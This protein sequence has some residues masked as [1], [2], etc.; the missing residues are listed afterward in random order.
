MDIK[1]VAWSNLWRNRGRYLAYLGSAAFAVMVYFLFNAVVLHPDFQSGYRGARYAVA[2]MR[3]GAVV[4]AAFTFFFLLFAHGSLIRFRRREFGLMRLMG[5]TRGQLVRLLLWESVITAAAS[6][7]VGSGLGL[8]FARLFF[9][10]ISVI[11]DLPEPIPVYAGAPVWLRTAGVFGAIF[12]A[13]SLQSIGEVMKHSIAELLRS[14]RR[15]KEPP[16]YSRG[17]AVLGTVL[18]AVGYAWAAL[19][20]QEHMFL[21]SMPV[22]AMVSV[23]TYLLIHEG[24]IALLNRLR[25]NERGFYRPVPF[26]HLSQLLFKL[27][28]NARTLTSVSLLVAVILT[29]MGTIYSVYAL[30][31]EDALRGQVHSLEIARFGA[32][33]ADLA[34]EAEGFTMLLEDQGLEVPHHWSLLTAWAD[35]SSQD[36]MGSVILVPYSIYRDM[37]EAAGQPAL[38]APEPDDALAVGFGPVSGANPQPYV[39]TLEDQRLEGLA[40]VDEGRSLFYLQWALV[41]ADETFARLTAQAPEDRRIALAAW[42]TSPDLGRQA[43]AAH[44]AVREHVDTG[45]GDVFLSRAVRYDDQVSQWSIV[46]FMAVFA[47]L[48][49]FAACCSLIY[50]RL[51][52]EIEDDRRY[53]RRLSDL[54]VGRDL[55]RQVNRRQLVTLFFVPF[56]IGSVHFTFAM[57]ALSITVGYSVIHYG[58]LMALGYLVLYA[59]YF[60]AV[61]GFYWRSLRLGG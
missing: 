58:W 45:S 13:V 18:L 33:A 12:A 7:A 11:L 48:V 25:R 32:G 28:D 57:R 39:L 38:P 51:S 17:K 43:I 22:T 16:T 42:D 44:S 59:L 4:V 49:F 40:H 52:A 20:D 36:L 3:A 2:A 14:R 61:Q 15:T 8:L 10:A 24:S 27:K 26:L 34:A 53:Y 56:L 60:L 19:G 55:L 30:A 21:A 41:V 1:R 5:F 54:G 23:G 37:R 31:R 46:L 47:S 6:L 9:M 35:L 29:A 50:F